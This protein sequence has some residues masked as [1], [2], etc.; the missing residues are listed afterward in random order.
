MSDKAIEL[1]ENYND[2]KVIANEYLAVSL[3]DITESFMV[4]EAAV[5]AAAHGRSGEMALLKRISDEPYICVT[6]T[7]TPRWVFS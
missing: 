6:D 5:K 1:F 2:T 7:M 3:T 4:G